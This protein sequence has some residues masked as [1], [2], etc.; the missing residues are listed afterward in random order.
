[1]LSCQIFMTFDLQGH[2]WRYRFS[3][4]LLRSGDYRSCLFKM[5]D[6]LL[7]SL[8][9]FHI[10]EDNQLP[11]TK[12]HAYVTL[13]LKRYKLTKDPSWLITNWLIQMVNKVQIIWF[14][15][16]WPIYQMVLSQW[17]PKWIIEE[18]I[19]VKNLY[20]AFTDYAVYKYKVVDESR[21]IWR[22]YLEQ[23]KFDLAIK[24]CN[25]KVGTYT[26]LI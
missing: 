13:S 10:H 4:L 5:A 26:F 21:N 25:D 18:P 3:N 17:F 1:M 6:F 14:L 9:L 16:W 7:Q 2:L 20:W 8:S 23:G 22:I 19:Q 24:H 11:I 15:F 12:I